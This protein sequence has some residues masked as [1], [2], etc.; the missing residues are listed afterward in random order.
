MSGA[1]SSIASGQAAM[2]PARSTRRTVPLAGALPI[3]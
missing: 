2:R 3:M 1:A